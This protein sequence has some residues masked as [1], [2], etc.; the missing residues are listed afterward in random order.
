MKRFFLAVI[1]LFTFSLS[2]F[3]QCTPMWVDTGYGISPDTIVNLPSGNVGSPY[4]AVVQF[5][6]PSSTIY[7]NQTIYIDHVVLTN[8]DGLSSIPGSVPFYFQCNPANCAF[9][10]DSVGCVNIQGTPTTPGTYDLT[11]QTNVYITA[12]VYLPF[13]TTG[14]HIV[15]NNPI[16][17]APISQ[18]NFDVSQNTPNPVRTKTN[19]YVNLEHAG[20][21]TVKI[22]NLVGNEVLKQNNIGKKG[23]NSTSIDASALAS[24]IYF[25]TVSDGEH[26][27]TK[28]LVV[29]RK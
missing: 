2:A 7:N 22:S 4:S 18:T 29:D 27:I 21:F 10:A 17:I 9:Y 12:V 14:Y 15:V 1:I 8:V 5:K 13:S 16:G 24:G 6:T 20:N 28:R 11:I 25:Y 3:S 26:S 19:V 23:F